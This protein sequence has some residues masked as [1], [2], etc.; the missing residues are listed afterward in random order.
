MTE[1]YSHNTLDML[2]ETVQSS[3]WKEHIH[4]RLKTNFCEK[5]LTVKQSENG[6]PHGKNTCKACQTDT[7]LFFTFYLLLL[8]II[9][10]PW[11]MNSH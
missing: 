2:S 4:D 3:A 7:I 8:I 6:N 5:T 1:K 11:D 10:K 9:P